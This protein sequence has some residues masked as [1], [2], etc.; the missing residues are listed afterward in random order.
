MCARAETM[1]E[2]ATQ[3]RG[4]VPVRRKAL[5]VLLRYHPLALDKFMS[6]CCPRPTPLPT[7]LHLA[8][9]L[10][11]AY[12]FLDTHHVV[13]L[14]AK[15]NNVLV[16]VSVPEQ[17]VCVLADFGTARVTAA[18]GTL[19]RCVKPVIFMI[20]AV[21]FA[22]YFVCIYVS[23]RVVVVINKQCACVHHVILMLFV[24]CALAAY[25]TRAISTVVRQKHKTRTT[26]TP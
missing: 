11:S 4:G 18:D 17:P 19:P 7:F 9:G 5:L 15:A 10:L 3:V 25:R 23:T 21:C 14:D 24:R 1:R 12:E 2:L 6:E 8:V 16:D 26:T 22:G 20:A 13:H